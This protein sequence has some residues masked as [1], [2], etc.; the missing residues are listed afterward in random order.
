MDSF[1]S[2]LQDLFS[3]EE[4]LQLVDPPAPAPDLGLCEMT[5][6]SLADSFPGVYSPD[7]LA[8]LEILSNS[9]VSW[10]EIF[11]QTETHLGPGT[12]VNEGNQDQFLEDLRIEDVLEEP[13]VT[14]IPPEPEPVLE[15]HQ[16]QQQEELLAVKEEG[17]ADSKVFDDLFRS[18]FG[19]SAGEDEKAQSEDVLESIMKFDID[20]DYFEKIDID[21]LEPGWPQPQ[22]KEE[23]ETGYSSVVMRDHDYT[24]PSVFPPTPPHSPD[25]PGQ[26]EAEG[27]E[28]SVTVTVVAGS[29]AVSNSQSGR[30]LQFVINLPVRK[31][32]TKTKSQSILKRNPSE[33]QSR[34]K[35]TRKYV[36]IKNVVKKAIGPIITASNKKKNSRLKLEEEKELHSVKERQ[37]RNELNEAFGYLR[38]IVP[39]VAVKE[40]ASKLT[41]LNSAKDYCEGLEGKLERLE[42][43]HQEELVRQRQ[44]LERRMQLECEC[45]PAIHF[46]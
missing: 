19:Q 23:E 25:K 36:T 45:S 46:T 5:D 21:S 17:E 22:E 18:M 39:S 1:G 2:S 4:V 12:E 44:L 38:E 35:T 9:A 27:E 43:L 16:Q 3:Q 31:E 13:L 40:K 29:E 11:R 33:T 32:V 26:A 10:D 37:R 8:E 42:T 6:L 34:G 14:S 28:R 30:D 15:V 41:I 24:L 7:S 20:P